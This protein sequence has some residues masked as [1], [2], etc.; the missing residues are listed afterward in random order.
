MSVTFMSGW[1]RCR[2]PILFCYSIPLQTYNSNFKYNFS[3]V[4][5]NWRE[6]AKWIGTSIIK[7]I[8]LNVFSH[9]RCDSWLQKKTSI[10]LSFALSTHS[11]WEKSYR[12]HFRRTQSRWK[13]WWNEVDEVLPNSFAWLPLCVDVEI[14]QIFINVNLFR[15]ESR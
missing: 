2:A 9:P 3:F 5:F 15:L 6:N 4:S 11:K 10:K 12:W 1:C 14:W 13:M 8:K 7:K